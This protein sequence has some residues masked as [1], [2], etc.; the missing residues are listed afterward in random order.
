MKKKVTRKYKYWVEICED[1]FH[2]LAF[3]DSETF[4]AHVEGN[5]PIMG[6]TVVVPERTHK[7]LLKVF[8]A[9]YCATSLNWNTYAPQ[10][11]FKKAGSK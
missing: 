5:A 2:V 6:G 10:F 3:P 11:G 8:R 7:R 1:E 9:G 4:L